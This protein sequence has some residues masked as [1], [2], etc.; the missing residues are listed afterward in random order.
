MNR[1]TLRDVTRA[2]LQ[3]AFQLRVP[4]VAALKRHSLMQR[5][6]EGIGRH[7]GI[8][9]RANRPA[10]KRWPASQTGQDQGS[11]AGEAT[12]GGELTSRAAYVCTA[13][14]VAADRRARIKDGRD[15]PASSHMLAGTE[16]VHLIVQ[17]G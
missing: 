14:L 12:T 6:A 13:W 16:G 15:H 1:L 11:L 17:P 8:A 2:N 5:R 9:A 10:N 7:I 4:T 3:A